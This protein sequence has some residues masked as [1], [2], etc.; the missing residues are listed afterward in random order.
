[1]CVLRPEGVFTYTEWV[2]TRAFGRRFRSKLT[3]ITTIWGS[4]FGVRSFACNPE[5][6][7]TYVERIKRTR[8][9][10]ITTHRFHKTLVE[11]LCRIISHSL[12][13]VVHRG[14]LDNYRKVSTGGYGKGDARNL[15]AE[16]I[17]SLVVES[18][19][20]VHLVVLPGLE[21]DDEI[22]LL[23]LL[24]RSHTEEAAN[25]YY[26][27]SAKLNVVSDELG[28]LTYEC[29]RRNALDL[30]GIVGDK[31]VTSLDKLYRGLALTDSESPR[32]RIPS[33]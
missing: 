11:F 25:V 27:Y 16:Y 3:K 23:G 12:L 10:K 29:G 17:R 2:K 24:Y 22:D 9:P 30:Y 7:F 1:M 4:K 8:L 14:N 13:S 33:P 15:D 26:S 32:R 5:D 31:S 6:V 19:T 21:I 28:C 18:E 20:V